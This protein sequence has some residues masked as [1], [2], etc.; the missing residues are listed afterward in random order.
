MED[1]GQVWLGPRAAD[2]GTC[3]GTSVIIS[4]LPLLSADDVPRTFAYGLGVA[5]AACDF[6]YPGRRGVVC[7]GRGQAGSMVRVTIQRCGEIG[8]VRVKPW[9]SKAAMVGV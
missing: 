9:L 2:D 8:C 3:Y 1:L 6:S 7:P 4:N 5:A